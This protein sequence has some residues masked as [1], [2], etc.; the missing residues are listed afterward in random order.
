MPSVR[1]GQMEELACYRV[2][3]GMPMGT[4]QMR[5]LTPHCK[6]SIGRQEH[7]DKTK[8]L[9]GKKSRKRRA[10]W[11]VASPPFAELGSRL[12][13]ATHHRGIPGRA[14]EL[15][16]RMFYR[17][18]R[19]SRCRSGRCVVCELV[20]LELFSLQYQQKQSTLNEPLESPHAPLRP[21]PGTHFFKDD[22]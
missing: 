13:P 22:L 16:L 3:P 4:G 2:V 12:S 19:N 10:A 20:H 21:D 14:A 8:E 9:M 18:L 15:R 17:G 7:C 1:P 11:N 6:H 5:T